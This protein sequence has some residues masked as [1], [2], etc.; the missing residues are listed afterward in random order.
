MFD[1][2]PKQTNDFALLFSKLDAPTALGVAIKLKVD[3]F[4][5]DVLDENG[6]P[7]PRS[8]ESILEDCV[9]KFHNLNRAERRALLKILK[10]KV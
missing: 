3:L 1:R 7:M 4:Y 10:A 5:N 6:R 2:K 9:V 8:G